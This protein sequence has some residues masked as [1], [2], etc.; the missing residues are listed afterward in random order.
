MAKSYFYSL[1]YKE[2]LTQKAPTG[3]LLLFTDAEFP[4]V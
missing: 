2:D 3:G 4:L 1:R